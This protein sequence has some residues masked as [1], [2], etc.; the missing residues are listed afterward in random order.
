MT[1]VNLGF[2]LTPPFCSDVIYGNPLDQTSIPSFIQG[3]ANWDTKHVI[4]AG[5]R[6]MRKRRSQNLVLP[7]ARVP[8]QL[9][10]FH[11]LSTLGRKGKDFPGARP[12]L[13]SLFP[14]NARPIIDGCSTALVLRKREREIGF[15]MQKRAKVRK[16]TSIQSKKFKAFRLECKRRPQK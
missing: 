14:V 16:T 10:L 13:L 11:A 6:N 12:S 4:V 8:C 9:K 15:L 2:L 3:P 5:W 7:R 1:S